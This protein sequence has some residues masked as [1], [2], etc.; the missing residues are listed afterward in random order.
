M[1][2]G[3]GQNVR[4]FPRHNQAIRYDMIRDA[5]LTCA[6]KPTWISLIY[7]T[8]ATTKNVKQKNEKVKK[9]ICSEV[10]VCGIHVVSPEEE[11]EG[12]GGNDL[13]KRKL[14]VGSSEEDLQCGSLMTVCQKRL[15]LLEAEDTR[16]SFLEDI[17]VLVADRLEGR[18]SAAEWVRFQMFSAWWRVDRNAWRVVE[19]HGFDGRLAPGDWWRR[20]RVC[21]A[22]KIEWFCKWTG[23]VQ[24]ILEYLLWAERISGL[25]EKNQ[26][27]W[28]VA[29]GKSKVLEEGVVL[30]L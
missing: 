22:E 26:R 16:L 20:E 25:S 13:Q 14:V 9:R 2:N 27:L 19:N 1:A 29:A 6:Q 11:K 8:E 23:E 12:Y 28:S 18:Q 5:I 17:V 24:M 7:C 4:N 30:G 15:G 3:C 10:K 21:Q